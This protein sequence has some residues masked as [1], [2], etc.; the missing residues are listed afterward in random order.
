[1]LWDWKYIL[2]L[3]LCVCFYQI[4]SHFSVEEIWINWV[5]LVWEGT[6]QEM[7]TLPPLISPTAALWNDTVADLYQVLRYPDVGIPVEH[8]VWQRCHIL[9]QNCISHM[10]AML[11]F[12]AQT[13]QSSCLLIRANTFTAVPKQK[14]ISNFCILDWQPVLMCQLAG[15]PKIQTL[16]SLSIKTD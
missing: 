2:L 6:K 3:I 16:N 9:A 8:Q 5:R 4:V 14:E 7:L 12:R 13:W 10:S 11:G 15:D 1:M